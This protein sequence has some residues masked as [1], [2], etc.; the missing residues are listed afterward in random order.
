MDG[1]KLYF[2]TDQFT[3]LLK[4]LSSSATG[5][6]GKMNAQQMIEHL[7]CVFKVSSQKIILPL[8]TPLEFLPK[9]KAFL[10]S[11]KLF[12]EN[13]R[14]PETV[15]PEEPLPL[16]NISF[17]AAVNELQKEIKDFVTFFDSDPERKTLHPVFGDLNYEEWV[18]LHYKHLVHHAKQFELMD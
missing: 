1:Q 2:I 14:A 9:Y 16:R 13:T 6:W 15:F 11:D 18:L 10:L 12:R 5:K 17:T 7:A 4:A 8:H 3:P